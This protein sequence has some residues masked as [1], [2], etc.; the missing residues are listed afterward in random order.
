VCTKTHGAFSVCM[1]YEIIKDERLLDEF[2]GWLP[3]LAAHEMFYLSLFARRKYTTVHLKSDKCQIKR[4]TSKTDWL[5]DKIRQLEVS[6]GAYRQDGLEI[7]QESLALYITVNPRNM[8]LAAKNLLVTLAQ[9]ITHPYNGYNPRSM[10]MSEIHKACS[11]KVWLDFDFDHNQIEDT[12]RGAA[13]GINEDCLRVLKTR[14]GFHLLVDV[15]RVEDRYN[16]TWYR[17]LSALDGVDV[18]GDNLIPVVGCT[19][20]EFVPHFIT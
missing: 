4:I 12:L 20:G 11:R 5:K 3:E 8:E 16:K 7:P 14:G 6:V 17:H 15:N 13:R 2:I 9:V 10:A 19:Q 1:N 18:K